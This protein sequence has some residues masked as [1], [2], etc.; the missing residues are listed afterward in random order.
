MKL[1]DKPPRGSSIPEAM[2][3]G[4]LS[5]SAD[6]RRAIGTRQEPFAVETFQ[7]LSGAVAEISTIIELSIVITMDCQ[8]ATT[9]PL[10]RSTQ[11]QRLP[12]QRASLQTDFTSPC[13]SLERDLTT[14]L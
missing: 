5:S 4:H 9:A 14:C 12:L 7:K 3:L 2:T 8:P 6:Y 10:H 1:L 11:G 13:F